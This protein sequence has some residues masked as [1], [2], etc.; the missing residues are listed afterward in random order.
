[1]PTPKP[2]LILH[3]SLDNRIEA[4][5]HDAFRELWDRAVARGDAGG[6]RMVT[7]TMVREAVERRLRDLLGA[8]VL[9]PVVKVSL[10]ADRT[11]FDIEIRP[12]SV[13]VVMRQV[14]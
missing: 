10:N 7:P 9:H 8:N 14:R 5:A 1:M 13:P 6:S 4:E 3:P 12:A 2:G 11:G